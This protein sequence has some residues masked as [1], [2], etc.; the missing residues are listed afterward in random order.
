MVGAWD[1]VQHLVDLNIGNDAAMVTARLLLAMRTR[2]VPTIQES[3]SVARGILGAPIASSGF[4]AYRR[5]YE[6]AL[7]LHMTHEL[8]LIYNTMINAPAPGAQGREQLGCL[9]RT[10]SARLDAT[11]PTFRTRE[12]ILSMRRAAFALLCDPSTL[13]MFVNLFSVPVRPPR[14]LAKLAVHGS[15]VRR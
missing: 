4:S 9:V 7:G 10:L 8:E 14:T 11:L 6:A 13:I 2:N 5:S 15:P 1:D 12:P 3:L